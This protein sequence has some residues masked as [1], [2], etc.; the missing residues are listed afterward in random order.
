L[1]FG[2]QH[3]AAVAAG[4]VERLQ[5]LVHH[6]D[7]A[8]RPDLHYPPIAR[9]G[10]LFLARHRD[11]LRIPERRELALVV[12]RVGVPGGR[13]A[14]FQALERLSFSHRRAIIDDADRLRAS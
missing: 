2:A 8:L 7:E 4:V 13:Q 3:G 11:P 1:L 12:R 6:Q 5:L 10:Q 14:G 9:R